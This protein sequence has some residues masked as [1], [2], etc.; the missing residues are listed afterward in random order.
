MTGPYQ[1]IQ[2]QRLPAQLF[3]TVFSVGPEQDGKLFD[4]EVD[5]ILMNNTPSAELFRA[6][7]GIPGD[8]WKAENVLP[9][10]LLGEERKTAALEIKAIPEYFYTTMGLP[11]ITP[12]M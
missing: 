1:H 8:S 6:W 2:D 5:T 3:G 11:V 4:I 7:Q 9:P 12:E 10:S